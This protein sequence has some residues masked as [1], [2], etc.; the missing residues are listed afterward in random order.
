VEIVPAAIVHGFILSLLVP[1]L[2]A[3]FSA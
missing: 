2:M 3:F 1:L